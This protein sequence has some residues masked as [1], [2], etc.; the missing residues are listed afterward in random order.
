M[1]IRDFKSVIASN[2]IILQQI[3]A[4]VAAPLSKTKKV[5]MI[6][7]GSGDVGAARLTGEIFSIV[8]KVPEMVKTMTGVDVMKVK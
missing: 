8:T 3:A 7:S 4:E 2:G 1:D 5:T 6:A